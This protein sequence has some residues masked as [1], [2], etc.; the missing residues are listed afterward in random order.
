MRT[1][2]IVV[3]AGAP[4]FAAA[5]APPA[6]APEAPAMPSSPPAAK[7]KAPPQIVYVK[8]GRLFDGTSDTVRERMA[9]LIEGERIKAVAPEAQ[10]PAPAGAKIVDLSH[11]TVLPGLIDCHVHLGKRADQWDPILEFRNTPNHSAFAAVKNAA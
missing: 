8:A 1:L 4:L 2:A 10:L 5:C 9:L 6:R 11:A 7:P 3:A